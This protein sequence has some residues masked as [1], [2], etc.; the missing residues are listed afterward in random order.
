MAVRQKEQKEIS[1]E[2]LTFK[3]NINRPKRPQAASNLNNAGMQKYLEKIEKAKKL[4]Q[5]KL[6]LE[7]KVF[8]TG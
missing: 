2:N 8:K 5:E 3:P 1:N 6:D 4:K 7:H